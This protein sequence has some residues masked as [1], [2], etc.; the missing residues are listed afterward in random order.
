MLLT[1]RDYKEIINNCLDEDTYWD[2]QEYL[3]N[4][5]MN[6]KSKNLGF[7][8]KLQEHTAKMFPNQKKID[9]KI[10]ERNVLKNNIDKGKGIL[11]WCNDELGKFLATAR[12][13]KSKSKGKINFPKWVGNEEELKKIYQGLVFLKYIDCEFPS[14]KK[15]FSGDIIENE[16][17]IKWLAIGKSKRINKAEAFRLFLIL[18]DKKKLDI[19]YTAMPKIIDQVFTDRIGKKYKD[20]KNSNTKN[21]RKSQSSPVIQMLNTTIA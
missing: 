11:F 8:L 19:D 3:D 5:Y 10:P 14:F 21:I 2:I 4:E 20:A 9:K 16:F 17:S 6:H 13:E 1:K 15:L 18:S 12:S 7:V